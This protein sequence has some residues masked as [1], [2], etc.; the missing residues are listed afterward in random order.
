MSFIHYNPLDGTSPKK[1]QLTLDELKSVLHLSQEQAA[2]VL[3]TSSFKLRSLFKKHREELSMVR[4]PTQKARQQMLTN[5][6]NNNIIVKEEEEFPRDENDFPIF[7]KSLIYKQQIKKGNNPF[8]SIEPKILYL[9]SPLENN[10][11]NVNHESI[12]SG[13]TDDDK[14]FTFNKYELQDF[15]HFLEMKRLE[16]D[17]CDRMIGRVANGFKKVVFCMPVSKCTRN[18]FT[19]YFDMYGEHC[20]IRSRK[21]LGYDSIGCFTKGNVSRY[22]FEFPYLPT[23]G[24]GRWTLNQYSLDNNNYES[25]FEDGEGITIFNDSTS[26]TSS[27]SSNDFSFPVIEDND[28]SFLGEELNEFNEHCNRQLEFMEGWDHVRNMVY[29]LSVSHNSITQ[30]VTVSFGMISLKLWYDGTY[31]ETF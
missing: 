14:I 2:K 6:N 12:Y 29:R 25:E 10:Q 26:T 27:T 7:K 31:K 28:Y 18:V 16:K 30:L 13:Y 3:G 24:N 15:L 8:T 11:H 9:P 1:K 19:S 22:V 23:F 21:V 4:W 5:N 17:I 20:T